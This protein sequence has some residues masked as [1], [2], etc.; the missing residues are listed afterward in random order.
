MNTPFI[1]LRCQTCLRPVRRFSSSS[2][3]LDARPATGPKPAPNIKHIRD[4]AGLYAQNCLDRNYTALAEYPSRIQSLADEAARLQRSLNAPRSK[5]KHVQKAIA[6]LAT[7]KEEQDN[8]KNEALAALHREAKQLKDASQAL[9]DRREAC[10]QQIQQLA[11]ALPN[12]TAP[13]TPVGDTPRVRD[14]INYNPHSPPPYVSSPEPARN[15]VAIGTAL[16]LLDF[17]SAATSTGWG[18]Y[19]LTNEGALLEQAL[20]QYALRVAMRRGWKPVAPPSLVYS[21]IAEACGFQPRDAQQR[22]AHLGHRAAR[23]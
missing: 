10:L 12:L 21:Y 15:H 4:H 7:S 17:A 22:A 16:G 8:Y 23:A 5:I 14:Y 9:T 19:Y 1:C 2:R 3:L 13:E 6:R 20:V 11:L 18:W